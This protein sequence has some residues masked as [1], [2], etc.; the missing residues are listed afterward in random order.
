[1]S[2]RVKRVR[3]A[4]GEGENN[5]VG[6]VAVNKEQGLQHYTTTS[7]TSLQHT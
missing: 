4:E 2:V 1:M 7:H 6:V 5:M 3:E